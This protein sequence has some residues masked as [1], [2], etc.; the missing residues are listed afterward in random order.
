MAI[1]FP[2]SPIANETHTDAGRTWKWDGTSWRL[3]GNA[4]NYTHPDHTGDVTS[5]ADGAT[6]IADDKVE[7]KHIN[8]GGTVGPDKVLVY[9]ASATGKWKWADQ[10]VGI[11]DGDKGDI[12]VSNSGAT[13][14]IDDDAVDSAEIASGAV[15][16]DHLSASGTKDNTTYLRGDNTWA[17]I[18]SGSTTL[19]ALTDTLINT[20]TL[21]QDQI[22]KYN[23]TKWVNDTV[24]SGVGNLNQVLTEGNT[25]LLYT[26][27]SP[28]D[29]EESRMP[30]SA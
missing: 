3:E 28:R 16:L 5:N 25:C 12:T 8:A 13:W 4:S 14:S 7:E 2:D 26:S 22:L 23:G 6:T 1:N 18:T 19:E 10:S 17:T 21:A 15:D 11:T 29:V 20:S 30:S 9:D 24:S 27:P